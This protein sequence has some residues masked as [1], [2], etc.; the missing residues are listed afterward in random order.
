[1]VRKMQKPG[2]ARFLHKKK[3]A[4]SLFCT[5]SRTMGTCGTKR[6]LQGD[7]ITRDRK[8]QSNN[9]ITDLFQRLVFDCEQ[10]VPAPLR[11]KA[12]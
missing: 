8:L 12:L 2:Q 7:T 9:E 1:M 3:T 5:R 10:T 11:E 6:V 4:K